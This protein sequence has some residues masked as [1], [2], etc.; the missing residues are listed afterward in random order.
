MELLE[1]QVRA[2][3]KDEYENLIRIMEEG[4]AANGSDVS[5]VR[6]MAGYI[7]GSLKHQSCKDD[8]EILNS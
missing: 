1:D 5:L 2:E 6:L 7:A 4:P 3:L 8:F